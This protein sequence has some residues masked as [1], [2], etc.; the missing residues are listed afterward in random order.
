MSENE[1][2]SSSVDGHVAL[3]M[4]ILGLSFFILAYG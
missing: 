1:K 2:K 4:V 3:V